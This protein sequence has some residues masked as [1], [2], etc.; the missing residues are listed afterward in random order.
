MKKAFLFLIFAAVLLFSSSVDGSAQRLVPGQYVLSFEGTGWRDYGGGVG[1]GFL[2]RNMSFDISAQYRKLKPYESTFPKTDIYPAMT[3][4]F[5]SQD[6]YARIMANFLVAHDRTYRWNLWCGISVDN[7]ARIRRPEA[8][9]E[10][11]DRVQT[12]SYFFGFTPEVRLE[13]FPGSSFSINAFARPRL[14]FPVF[15]DESIDES[16]FIPEFG[17]RFNFYFFGQ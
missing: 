13:F 17:L 3:F 7:G 2:R 5:S 9:Y 4:G 11:W 8:E 12:T 16:C 6:I 1:F 14:A 15:S 10:F